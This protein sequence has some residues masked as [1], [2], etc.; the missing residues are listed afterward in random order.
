MSLPLCAL[1]HDVTQGEDLV[2][3]SLSFPKPCQLS[4][5]LLVHCVSFI[6]ARILP[7]TDS[8]V[9]PCQLLRAPFFRIFT[10]TL[11]VQSSGNFFPSLMSVK[12]SWSKFAVSCGSALKT[13][14]LR[15]SCPGEFFRSWGTRWLQWSLL[16]RGMGVDIQVCLCLLY[17]CLCWWW[18]SVQN[19]TEVF[20]PSCL[21]QILLWVVTPACP[22]SECQCLLCTCHT[23]AQWS[24]RLCL[25]LP[26][27][28]HLL[29]GLQGRLCGSDERNYERAIGRGG[30]GT[31]NDNGERPLEICTTYDFVI[32][33]TLFPHQDL[34]L[35]QRK[36]E[37]DKNQI[38]HL[39]INRMWRWSLLDVQ[40]RRGADVG[41]DHHLATGSSLRGW[42]HFGVE[43]LWDL[44]VKT[45]FILQI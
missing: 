13:S 16:F 26:C 14:A 15:L 10:M 4:S 25:A 20:H 17:I 6:L 12:S 3:A 9:I 8:K 11:S 2:C 43:K 29:P 27:L 18:W 23:P 31:M 34:V 32:G 21:P 30:C 44:K 19:F 45:A 38:D 41:S 33:G 40:E 28:L 39:M 42:Q 35:P 22:W 37:R 5:Q 24:W 1:F 7:G 36:R